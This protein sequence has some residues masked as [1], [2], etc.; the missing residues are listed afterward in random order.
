MVSVCR[1]YS[2]RRFFCVLCLPV[3]VVFSPTQVAGHTPA[4][5]VRNFALNDVFSTT[6]LSI[7]E[8][9]LF[10]LKSTFNIN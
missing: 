8:N 9:D 3:V 6:L 2:E 4:K 10:G 7:V 5:E 1:I